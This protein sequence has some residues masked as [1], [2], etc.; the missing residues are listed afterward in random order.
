MAQQ[1]STHS[2]LHDFGERVAECTGKEPGTHS[3]PDQS[4]PKSLFYPT[5]KADFK[6]LAGNVQL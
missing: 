1:L 4:L 3:R 6:W 2:V 5:G